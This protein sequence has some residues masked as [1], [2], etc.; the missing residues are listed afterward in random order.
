MSSFRTF[1]HIKL[2]PDNDSQTNKDIVSYIDEKVAELAQVVYLDAVTRSKL[3]TDL[4]ERAGGTVL[5]VGFAA[6]E[7]KKQPTRS[8]MLETMLQM[9]H[10]LPAFYERMLKLIPSSRKLRCA[11]ILRWVILAHEVLTVVDLAGIPIPTSGDPSTKEEVVET[12]DGIR[13]CGDILQLS[14]ESHRPRLL[15]NDVFSVSSE[16]LLSVSSTS[17]SDEL[18]PAYRR[19]RLVHQSARDYLLSTAPAACGS[20]KQFAISIEV[21]QLAMLQDCLRCLERGQMKV[22]CA[23][24]SESHTTSRGV[25][26]IGV[27][28]GISPSLK[29]ASG[30][31]YRHADA[32]PESAWIG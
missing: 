30:H 7:L 13:E 20:L 15:D 11:K 24:D 16:S 10:G 23:D 31:W 14:E 27:G 12:L 1:T 19:L 22:A 18:R 25:Q 3:R 28:R 6:S 26:Q 5:W 8:L 29:Y 32:V 9:P 4:A 2:D 17:D 21:D